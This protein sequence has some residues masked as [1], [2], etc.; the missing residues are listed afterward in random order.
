ME[1]ASFRD[2]AGRIYRHDGVL[3]R[4]I[5]ELGRADYDLFMNSGLYL[6]L[7]TRGLLVAHEEVSVSLALD[8]SA[9]KVIRPETIPYVSYPWEWSFSQ[10]KDA[11]LLTLQVH[12]CALEHGFILK[13]ASAFNVQFL[14]GRPI[15]ID[16]LSFQRY[17]PGLPWPA[18]RQFCQ[19]FAA[20]LA[21][22]A[23]CDIRLLNLMKSF[24]DGIPLDLASKLL[25]KRSWLRY[26][27][28]AHIHLHA[29]AQLVYSGVSSHD[30]KARQV[31]VSELGM[32]AMADSLKKLIAG[33]KYRPRKTEWGDYYAATNYVDTA[34]DQKI[35]LVSAALQKLAGEGSPLLLDLGANTGRFSRL[36]LAHGFQVVAM[37]VDEYAVEQSYIRAVTEG[38]TGIL[39]LVQDL[40]NPSPALGWAHAERMSLQQRG[41]VRVVMALALIHH[42]AISN[43][44]PLSK[45]AH[46]FASLGLN[47]IIEFVP[48]SDSQVQRLLS[49]REDIFPNYTQEDFEREFQQF[50]TLSERS[51]IADSERILYVFNVR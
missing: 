51:P 4:Q 41:P 36:G 28:L 3:Y 48:K 23:L 13:D 33:L 14:R 10:L 44:V 39:P 5:N 25:P 9:Y 35:T 37:D 50:F 1:E 22:A 21:V 46:F 7:E 17:E 34:M 24:I 26:S 2:P 45:C 19:H 49:T 6:D 30:A 32:R 16:T 42:L 31:K 27:I 18:Y 29:R 20:P 15:F 40:T 8:T 38:E 11:A 47:L 43:N 12:M